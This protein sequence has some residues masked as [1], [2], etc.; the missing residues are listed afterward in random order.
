MMAAPKMLRLA[1]PD[2]LGS[3]LAWS[4]AHLIVP[5]LVV[6]VVGWA[7]AFSIAKLVNRWLRPV[8]VATPPAEPLRFTPRPW[9][10]PAS[11]GIEKSD[12]TRAVA[13]MRSRR[14]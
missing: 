13:E 9:G 14:A 1:W 12:R 8:R 5:A 11:K 2:F 6:V 7:I 10:E 4:D 3:T